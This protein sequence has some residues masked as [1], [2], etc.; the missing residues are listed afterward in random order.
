[1]RCDLFLALSLPHILSFR[2]YWNCVLPQVFY[3]IF[4]C[5]CPLVWCAFGVFSYCWG[6]PLLWVAFGESGLWWEWPLVRVAFGEWG[7]LFYQQD[8]R[9]KN[10]SKIQK[11]VGKNGM[12][13]GHTLASIWPWPLLLSGQISDALDKKLLLNCLPE[14]PLVRVAF[15]ESGLWWEWSLVRVAFGESG[16]WWE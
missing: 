13:L 7:N 4:C 6:C 1:M 5:D 10:I 12:W 11:N 9:L 14:L 2:G 15:G 3:F 16:L 8:V